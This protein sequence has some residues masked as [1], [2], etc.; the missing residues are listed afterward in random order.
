M[1]RVIV[2]VRLAESNEG[3]DLEV[4]A[5]IPATELARLIAQAL[6]FLQMST[7]VTQYNIYVEPLGRILQPEEKLIDASVWDGATLSLHSYP[8]AYF[9]AN[10]GRRYPCTQPEMW[11]GRTVADSQQQT[12]TLHWLDLSEEP[13][14]KTVSRR[15]ARLFCN[16]GQWWLTASAQT[17]NSILHNGQA[18]TPDKP[19]VLQGGDTVQFG[20]VVLQFQTN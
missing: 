1:L 19:Q 17:M 9:V 5:E 15:H 16:A 13:E 6:G 12:P 2:Y 14:G 7:T 11:I 20:G 8:A 10:S 3:K 4:P 18:L